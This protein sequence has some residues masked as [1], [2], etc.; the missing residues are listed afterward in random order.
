MDYQEDYPKFN[1]FDMSTEEI[2]IKPLIIKSIYWNYEEEYRF[3]MLKK[4]NKTVTLEKGILSDVILGC[5]M[6]EQDKKDIK[7]ILHNKKESINLYESRMMENKFKL[8]F[9]KIKY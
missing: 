1:P 2:I 9:N 5:K 8:E 3:I 6:S 4:T 7:E